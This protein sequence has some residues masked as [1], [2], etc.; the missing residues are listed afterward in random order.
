M[1]HEAP[2]MLL[3]VAGADDFFCLSC[4]HLK[5]R[6]GS[7]SHKNKESQET[8]FF[9]FFFILGGAKISQKVICHSPSACFGSFS[10]CGH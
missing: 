4:K 7:G 9:I 5:V 8:S 10:S 2:V 3:Q 1:Q 6:Q